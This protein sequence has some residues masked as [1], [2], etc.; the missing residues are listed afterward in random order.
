MST[1]KI[2][3]S[4]PTACGKS[5]VG[6]TIAGMLKEAGCSVTFLDDRGLV[7][8]ESLEALFLLCKTLELECKGSSQPF[9]V[10]ISTQEV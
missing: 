4:G 5:L 3:L 2:T 7:R 9:V 6:R 1:L 8:T 10:E